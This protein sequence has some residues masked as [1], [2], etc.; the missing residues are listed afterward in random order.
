MVSYTM[1][2]DNKFFFEKKYKK[3]FA[4]QIIYIFAS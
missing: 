2:S 4:I 3:R 1:K